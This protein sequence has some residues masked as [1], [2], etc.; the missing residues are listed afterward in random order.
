MPPGEVSARVVAAAD[1]LYLPRDPQL[2]H[3][4][5][6]DSESCVPEVSLEILTPPC[7]Q[8]P[9]LVILAVNTFVKVRAQSCQPPSTD[10]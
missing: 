1:Q 5:C 3:E 9:D 7:L 4:L 2:P 6:Q 10:S 8:Q